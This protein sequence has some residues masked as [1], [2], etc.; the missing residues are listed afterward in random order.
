MHFSNFKFCMVACFLLSSY[1]QTNAQESNQHIFDSSVIPAKRLPQQNEFL[2]NTYNFPAKP[3]SQ[4]EAGISVGSLTVNGDLPSIFPTLGFQA[5]IRK[6]FGYIFSLRISY[7]NGNAKGMMTQS[8]AVNTKNTAWLDNSVAGINGNLPLGKGYNASYRNPN[9]DV[10]P[11]SPTLNGGKAQSVFTNYKTHIQDL[12][13]QGLLTLS[14]IRFH[15]QKTNIS[16]YGGGGIGLTSYHTMV[17]ALDESGN[18]YTALFNNVIAQFPGGADTRSEKK[19]L[20]KAL[21]DGMDNTYETEAQADGKRHGKFGKNSIMPSATGVIGAAYRLSSRINIALEERHTLT[22][23]DLLDGQQWQVHPVGDVSLSRDYDSYN[24]LSLGVNFNLG[25]KS[26]EPLWWLNPLD[27]AYSEINEPKHMKLPKP[28]L[29]DTDGDGIT[30]QL[31]REPNTPSG[32]AVDSH[33]VTKDTD[34]DGVPDCKDKQLITPTD[35]QP[36][37]AD[38]VGKCPE[39]A[40][41]DSLKNNLANLSYNGNC[42]TDYQ[43]IS[44]TQLKLSN[45][46][47][48]SLA[49]IAQKLK[50]HPTCSITIVGYSAP[51]KKTQAFTVKKLDLIKNYLVENAGITAERVNTNVLIGDADVNKID[52]Q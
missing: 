13:L 14:N 5:H 40:C 32:C 27:Y 26:V 11:L 22:K 16:L 31:D 49:I 25:A 28:V 21:K 8:S 43:S 23:S 4:W 18:N 47:K 10:V 45:D 7:L 39:P 50:D 29:D 34:G 15:K 46:A 42:P 17:N 9:G 6:S 38:G 36:V 44:L 2:N 20:K 12:S 48:A 19:N 51:N 24:F 41:C 52:F 3:R 37:D 33:G 35:C 1:I 30:D